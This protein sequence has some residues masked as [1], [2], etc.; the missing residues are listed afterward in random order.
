[1]TRFMAGLLLGLLLPACLLAGCGSGEIQADGGGYIH[2]EE[3]AAI[4]AESPAAKTAAPDGK[5]VKAEASGILVKESS[6]VS[7]D[8]SNTEDG[9]VMVKFKAESSQKIKAQ[10]KGPTTTYTYNVKPGQWEVFPLSDENGKYQVSVLKNVSGNKYAVLASQ[11]FTVKMKDEFAPFLLPNQYVNYAEAPETVKKAASLCKKAEEPLKKVEKIYKYVVKNFTYDTEKA[12]TVKSGYLPDLDKVLKAKKGICF[13]Y[14]AVMAGML[15]SEGVPCKLVVGY[16]GEAYHAWI[17][18]Y[19]EGEGW[20]E[21]VVYFDGESW[22][23]MDPTFASSGGQSKSIM[24][25][26]GDGSNYSAK[27][28]Y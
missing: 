27:Y 20:I 5:A 17:S 25:Y 24:K 16:A 22:Q 26:I 14:A 12:R 4:L 7:I 6:D 23:R 2:I 1:L 10:V 11:S 9:Y 15:R 3:E 18:V 19:V 21:G 8:Y 28:F 13:D